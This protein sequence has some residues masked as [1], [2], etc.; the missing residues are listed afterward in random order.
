MDTD[1]ILAGLRSESGTARL[2]AARELEERLKEELERGRSEWESLVNGLLPALT[3]AIGDAHKGVQVHAANCLEFF[4]YQSYAVIPA[5]RA[6]MAGPDPWRAWGAAL[7]TARMGLWFPEMAPALQGAMGAGDRDVRWA[8]A[9]QC[10]QLGRS[11]PEAVDT[12]KATLASDNPLARKMAAYCLGAM[13]QYAAVEPALAAG[14]SDPDRD[15]RRAVI[16]GID[17]LPEVSEPVQ[18]QIAALRQDPDIYV[19]RTA[20]AVAAKYDK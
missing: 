9:G 14:L 15:V 2:A 18:A 4:S 16:L 3:A 11:H 19:R 1:R 5:L 6:A 13:G 7:V 10:L 8:A 17:K 12:V 20:A